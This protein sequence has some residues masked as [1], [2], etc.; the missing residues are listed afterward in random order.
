MWVGGMLCGLN[1]TLVG[2]SL[3]VRMCGTG[4]VRGW[5]ATDKPTHTHTQQQA[6]RRTQIDGSMCCTQVKLLCSIHESHVSMC[7]G[8]FHYYVCIL[9]ALLCM[10]VCVCLF[11]A[12]ICMVVF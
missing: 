6:R 12:C 10:G 4:G 8:V 3:G 7:S 9:C 11:C 5:T 1:G 2:G